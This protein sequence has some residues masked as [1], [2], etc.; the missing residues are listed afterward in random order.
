M[1]DMEEKVQYQSDE[2]LRD[3]N[4]V[5]ENCQTRVRIR[6]CPLIFETHFFFR[7]LFLCVDTKNGAFIST[8]ICDS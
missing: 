2:R 4:E 1:A 6:L 8:T 5:L 3:V 7:N